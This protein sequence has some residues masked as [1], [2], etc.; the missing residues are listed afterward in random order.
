[1]FQKSFISSLAS[2]SFTLKV[3]T[4]ICAACSQ[5]CPL[6][7]S[8]PHFH[9]LL[10]KMT[11][12]GIQCLAKM[13]LLALPHKASYLPQGENYSIS[14]NSMLSAIYFLANDFLKI[15]TIKINY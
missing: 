9:A 6:P 15:E 4:V 8:T 10:L 12:H 14:D 5:R 1:M 3:F 11:K 13:K 2:K 7:L